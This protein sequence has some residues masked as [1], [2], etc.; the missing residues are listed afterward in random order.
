[1]LPDE[2]GVSPTQVAQLVTPPAFP[3]ADQNG[4]ASFNLDEAV[5]SHTGHL[6]NKP[7]SRWTLCP[8]CG[9]PVSTR[10]QVAVVTNEYGKPVAVHHAV[11]R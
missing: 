5:R 7:A 4:L 10:D 3:Q 9:K 6:C 1:M 11:C 8:S 2:F